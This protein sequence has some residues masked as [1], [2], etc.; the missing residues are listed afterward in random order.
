V[1]LVLAPVGYPAAVHSACQGE[2]LRGHFRSDVDALRAAQ[3]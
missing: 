3:L 1:G 2:R